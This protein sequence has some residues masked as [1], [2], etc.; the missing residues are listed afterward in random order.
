[1]MRYYITLVDPRF[2]KGGGVLGTPTLR[3][4]TSTFNESWVPGTPIQVCFQPKSGSIKQFSIGYHSKVSNSKSVLALE[5]QGGSPCS[6]QS[7]PL[8]L[9]LAVYSSEFLWIWPCV[10]IY[11]CHVP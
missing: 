2:G 6:L 5:S 1:M 10:T 11:K 8:V 9:Q 4:S 3:S 7:Q